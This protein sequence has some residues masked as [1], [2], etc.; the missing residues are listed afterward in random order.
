MLAR[1]RNPDLIFLDVQ[2][3]GM[4]G[5]EFLL[6]LDERWP[7]LIKTVPVV[8]LTAGDEVRNSKAVGHIHKPIDLLP[9]LST[10]RKYIAMGGGTL[11]LNH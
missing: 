2:M 11:A 9:F 5:P 10:T 3:N 6:A 7:D 1:I 8:F 4:S